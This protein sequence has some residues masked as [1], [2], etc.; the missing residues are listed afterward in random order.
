MDYKI[1]FHINNNIQCGVR[2]KQEISDSGTQL[3]SFKG[4]LSGTCACMVAKWLQKSL[5]SG[6]AGV[7]SAN[8]LGSEHLMAISHS[9]FNLV[10]SAVG[11]DRTQPLSQTVAMLETYKLYPKDD[12]MM[13]TDGIYLK[14][15]LDRVSSGNGHYGLVYMFTREDNNVS[16]HMV[17]FRHDDKIFQFFEPNVGLIEYP[18]EQN[19]RDHLMLVVFTERNH[20]FFSG[21]QHNP[22]HNWLLIPVEYRD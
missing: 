4:R 21:M 15:V 7:Q 14:A 11:A 22:K 20:I 1:V 18:D 9:A 17:G 12:S 3:R 2:W 10:A 6:Q 13:G 16:S 19:F 8:E 5:L